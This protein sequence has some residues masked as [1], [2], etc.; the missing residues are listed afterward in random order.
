MSKQPHIHEVLQQ[1]LIRYSQ[2]W[3][4]YDVLC[5]G[6][7]IQ[8]D[9]CVLSIGSAGCNALS[10]LLAGA[11]KVVAVDM[12]PAQIA[13]INLKKSAIAQCDYNSYLDLLGV[14]DANNALS[15][16]QKLSLDEKTRSYW[17]Q[18]HAILQEG[19]IHTGKLD[20]YFRIFQT[21]FI[22]PYVP[23]KIL[24][25]YLRTDSLKEQEA[26]FH[27]VFSAP[28]FVDMF[29]TYN[30]KEMI[31]SSGRDPAQFAYVKESETG[32]YF[33]DRFRYVCTRIPARD[34]FYLSY[35]LSGQYWDLQNSSPQYS[36]DGFNTL[37]KRIDDLTVVEEPL[38]QTLE[39]YE[40]GTF[41]KVNLSD[42]FEYLSQEESNA[43]F[44]LLHKRLRPKGRI[45]YWNLLVPRQSEGA[46][47]HYLKDLSENLW[48]RD[49]CFF[50]SRFLVEEKL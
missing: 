3:E 10:M 13:L 18:N 46:G 33:Y 6:L 21:K 49:R 24:A 17:D 2:V 40:K 38:G 47:F 15:I 28:A 37:K 43:L 36:S 4:D 11:K 39:R 26:F 29:K 44:T 5:R 9:D 41:S 7:D 20:R 50:Y 27:R 25:D 23:K 1:S 45:A 48:K 32:S 35:L 16:Y 12:N 19:I 22:Q 34:N 42:L 30:G 8:S 14:G 31:A